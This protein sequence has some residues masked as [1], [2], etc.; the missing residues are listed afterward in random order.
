MIVLISHHWCNNMHV[1]ICAERDRD[2]GAYNQQG[3][4]GRGFR[5][6]G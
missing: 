6:S 1:H 5:V 2:I 3:R 4:E